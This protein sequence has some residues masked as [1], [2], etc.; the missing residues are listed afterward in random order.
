LP[1]KVLLPI[2]QMPLAVLAAKR[3]ANTGCEVIVATSEEAS[4][5]ALVATLEQHSLK[6]YRGELE[7]TL[8]RFV[9]ALADYADDT[10]VFRLTAD[11]VFPDGALLDE[12]ADDFMTRDLDYLACNGLPSGLPYGMSAELMYL[13]DLRE[14]A[15]NM[16]NTFDQEH[17]TPYIV[18]KHGYQVFDKY[19]ARQAGMLRSTVDCLDD[20]L[21]IQT[22]FADV[23][24]PVS[25][26][27]FDLLGRLQKLSSDV[28]VNNPVKKLVLGTAQLGMNYGIANTSGK[29]AQAQATAMIKAAI[30]NGVEYIDTAQAYGDS[31]SVIGKA[32]AD[33]W[34]GR[35]K[36]ITK[37]SPL[38]DCPENV[39]PD[40]IK[41]F[42]DASVYS[43]CRALQMSSLD[44]LML[45][46]AEHLTAWNGRVWQYLL[47]L[48]QQGLIKALGVSIQTPNE[49]V[50]ALSLEHIEYI[51]MPFNLLDWRW[52][53]VIPHI[54][55]I[56]QERKLFIHVRSALLQGLLLSDDDAHW[57]RANVTMSDGQAINTWLDEQVHHCDRENRIDFC[58]AYVSGCDWVDGIALGMER[59]EQLSA[60]LALLDQEPLDEACIKQIHHSRPHVDVNTLNPAMWT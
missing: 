51:Q 42:V 41:A 59:M 21:A 29:P 14:A 30:A 37:L 48:K 4:D 54:Q 52:Q 36:V 55:Q 34:Q 16:Q 18:R 3:A 53:D 1:A 7:N 31:E 6:Y 57:Q 11:N 35:V 27:A 24:E 19:Y 22:V 44:V 9:A 50:Q 8:A 45:H 47:V 17:V 56:K 58:L 32:L 5:D 40:V 10:L 43:S 23:D 39:A 12:I 33:G 26:S 25:V 20:Y 49:L 46:R 60:N 2:G 28:V 38:S 13:R 15:A